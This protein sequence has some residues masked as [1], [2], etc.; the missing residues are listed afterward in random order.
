MEKEFVIDG[1]L[2]TIS[3]HE[4]SPLRESSARL[5]QLGVHE[6][7]SKSASYLCFCTIP[8]ILGRAVGEA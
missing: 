4:N 3:N 7:N 6:P 8:A 2:Q 1:V 5:L